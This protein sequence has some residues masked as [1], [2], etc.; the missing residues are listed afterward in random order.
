MSEK[1]VSQ[2]P[3]DA[4]EVQAI[5]LGIVFCVSVFVTESDGDWEGRRVSW[6]GRHSVI[7]GPL[8][9]VASF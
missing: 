6:S 2:C 7:L 3:T 4:L 9:F 8:V 5:S 1:H